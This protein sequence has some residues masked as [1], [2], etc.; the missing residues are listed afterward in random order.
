MKLN[1]FCYGEHMLLRLLRDRAAEFLM[2]LIEHVVPDLG[3]KRRH[4]RRRLLAFATPPQSTPSY[5]RLRDVFPARPRRTTRKVRLFLFWKVLWRVSRT[6]LSSNAATA[7]TVAAAA[8]QPQNRFSD[9]QRMYPISSPTHSASSSVLPTN[10]L[11]PCEG[12]SSLSS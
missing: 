12:A 4:F 5:S 10:A 6:C 11:A 9:N 7:T 1:C 2:S 3:P 8:A